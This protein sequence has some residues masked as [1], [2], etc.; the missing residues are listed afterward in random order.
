MQK[1]NPDK[2]YWYCFKQQLKELYY[3]L[4]NEK[5]ISCD[6]DEFITHFTGKKFNTD[7]MNGRKLIWNG[8]TELLSTIVD[9]LMDRKFIND[10]EF[11]KHFKTVTDSAEFELRPKSNELQKKLETV[12]PAETGY[13]CKERLYYRERNK[14]NEFSVKRLQ[15]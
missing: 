4:Y 13:R 12:F 15:K 2:I 7:K 1:N 5:F 3:L 9:H 8:N 11:E 14:K 6:L 10:R